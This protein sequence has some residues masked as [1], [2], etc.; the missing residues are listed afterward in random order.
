MAP[1]LVKNRHYANYADGT[2]PFKG[3]QRWS[4]GCSLTDSTLLRGRGIA[5]G[6]FPFV[7]D[8]HAPDLISKTLLPD[9]RPPRQLTKAGFQSR[10]RLHQVRYLEFLAFPRSLKL[11]L[12]KASIVITLLSLEGLMQAE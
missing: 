7:N 1:Q 3:Q 2:R 10:A 12:H 11:L 8:P 9:T 6:V 5:R 4:S